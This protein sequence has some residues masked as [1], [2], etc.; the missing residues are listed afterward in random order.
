MHKA[1]THKAL[2]QANSRK[3][4]KCV[5]IEIISSNY[6]SLTWKYVPLRGKDPVL[7][8]RHGI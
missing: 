2:G 8:V 4:H 7:A 1:L 5:K 3:Y 6:T